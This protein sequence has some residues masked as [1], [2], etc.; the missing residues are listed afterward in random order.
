MAPGGDRPFLST[1]NECPE[2]KPYNRPL[3]AG[4]PTPSDGFP[5]NRPFLLV[6]LILLAGSAAATPDTGLAAISDLGQLNGQAL[7]CGELAV[8]AQAKELVIRHA[9]K[10]RTYG[11][12]F[13]EQTNAG[14][15]AQ[16]QGR[17]PCPT[18]ADFA[19][20]LGALS[21]RLQTAL[22]APPAR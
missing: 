14:F 13:E 11:A 18:P 2:A 8:V 4:L 20:R 22:P 3:Y 19:G 1:I 15:L 5:M 9:P 10:T 17:E 21:G 7:A 6:T 16:G 12:L